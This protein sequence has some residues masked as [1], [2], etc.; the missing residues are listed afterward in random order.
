MEFQYYFVAGVV[1]I[2][3]ILQWAAYRSNERRVSRIKGLF[4]ET[5]KNNHVNDEDGVSKIVNDE[6]KDEFKET[7]D[8]INSYLEKNK[9]KTFDYHILEG[10]VER[11]AESLENEVDTML[12]VP[13][14]LGLMATIFGIAF[15]VVAFAWNDLA[16]L[17]SQSGSIDPQGIKIL[18]TDVGIA[19]IASFAGVYFTKQ[20]TTHFN[21]ARTTM[22]KNK[23]RF[24]T[25]IQTDLMSK[26]S[27]DITGA[28]LRMTSDL[29]EF[30]STFRNNTKELS[31]TLSSVS[32][33]YTEQ[34][35]LLDRINNLNIS[36]IAQAN[37]DVY[38]RLEGCT[39]ELQ[40]LFEIIA[41][42]EQ[43]LSRVIVLN[44]KIGSIEERT[45]L[46]EELG[47]YFHNELEYVKNRQG[48]M[49]QQMA[50]LDSVLQEAF[51][52][53][54]TNLTNSLMG[55]TAV[56]QRQNQNIQT[57]IEEQSNALCDSLINQQQAV[58]DKIGQINE[59]FSNVSE[60][61]KEGIAG[62][63]NAFSEQNAIISE[64]L[65]T[66]KLQLEETLGSQTTA[67]VN[68]LQQQQDAI[69]AKLNETPGQLQSLTDAVSALGRLNNNIEGLKTSISTPREI[70]IDPIIP[71]LNQ[72]SI[73]WPP[74]MK[75]GIPIGLFATIIAL[76]ALIMIQ[77][78]EIKV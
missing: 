53:L 30:N 47:N 26:L 19:M 51:S 73:K 38:T 62:I 78:F 36:Q 39:N 42:S 1:F 24:L 65:E 35:N 50:S 68:S 49:R 10:I 64:M 5:I 13:L 29:N 3:I 70:K 14:Y 56:F 66:Q 34:I 2:V 44:D 71:K 9:N 67:I 8:D 45:R 76:V 31:K 7:L 59:P 21:S 28:I 75:W 41:N 54:G 52:D 43:Y 27:D 60:I 69:L 57:L 25:W 23:N 61:F 11:N 17:L 40:R 33:N 77:L 6:A 18:L 48:Q 32:T 4:P 15:G 58:N 37:I 74:L 72:E 12:S 46:F 22:I 63:R 20:S 16:K 55:L